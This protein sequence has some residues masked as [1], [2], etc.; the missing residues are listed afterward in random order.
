MTD[1][2]FYSQGSANTPSGDGSLSQE[3]PGPM[4]TLGEERPDSYIYDPRDPLM[5]LFLANGHDGPFDQR[6][7]AHRRDVLTYQSEVLTA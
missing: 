3:P 6:Y 7:N 1:F 5:T 2:F 4:G